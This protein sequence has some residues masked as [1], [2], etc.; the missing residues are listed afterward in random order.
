M[1]DDDQRGAPRRALAALGMGLFGL[2]FSVGSYGAVVPA[3]IAAGV[4]PDAAGFGTTL[5]LL[6]QFAAVLPADALTRRYRTALVA[7][8]GF[9]LGG[10]GAALGGSLDLP[11]A[12]LSRSLVGLGTGVAFLASVKYA[13]LRTP[14][15][16]RSL[17]QGLLGAAF[18][19]GLA[20]GLAG[21]PPALQRFGAL[22][23]AVVAAVAAGVPAVPAAR[24]RPVPDG[25]VRSLEAYLAPLR[26][27]SGL[28]L[29][30]ANMA[31]FGLLIVATTWYADVLATE[32]ALPA[33]GVL[34]GF[35]LAT[36]LGRFGGGWLARALNERAAVAL[37]LAVLAALLAA[38]AAA[39]S[40][41]APLVLGAALVGTGAGFGLPFG[42][43]FS[44]AFS[45]LSD[46]PGVTLVGMT[47][48]GN[49]A[50]LAYPWLVGRLLAATES[51]A[52]GF[53]AMALT[54]ALVVALWVRTVGLVDAEATVPAGSNAQSE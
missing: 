54:V 19:L 42:P 28:S 20:A 47:A 48:V 2:G 51:Y 5:Y 37:T 18:T 32:P 23:I 35:S 36:V 44:L 33:T 3:L 30:L 7:A 34:V 41:D 45:N 27:P 16:H 39:I 40:L 50:A 6:G 31:S 49:A 25:S 1:R 26:S 14:S 53:V 43:L 10:V 24:L 4:A 52:A 9:A 11:V 8:G 15:G 17:A 22:P 38:V 29:G 21:G 46:D 13:G 12:Y